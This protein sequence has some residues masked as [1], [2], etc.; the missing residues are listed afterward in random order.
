MNIEQICNLMIKHYTMTPNQGKKKQQCSCCGTIES[1]TWC[2]GPTGSSSLCNAC[3]LQYKK[4]GERPRMI[5]LVLVG[6]TAKW[7]KR[8]NTTLKWKEWDANQTDPRIIEWK[9]YEMNNFVKSK[10]RKLAFF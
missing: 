10:K 9:Q 8:N 6:E 2:P 3:G 7:I 4:N 5:D 1:L